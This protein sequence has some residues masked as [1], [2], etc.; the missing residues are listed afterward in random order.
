MSSGVKRIKLKL[1]FASLLLTAGLTLGMIYINRPKGS[2]QRER[3]SPVKYITDK[4]YLTSQLKPEDIRLLKGFLIKT[5]VDI[6]PD[7]EGKDQASSEEIALASKENGLGFHYIPVPHEGIPENAVLELRRV[8]SEEAAP[9]LLYCRTGR[10]AVRLFA[11]E[12]ASRPGGPSV[13]SI[14][15]L[16]RDAGFSAD[17]LKDDI[18]RYFAERNAPAIPS[19]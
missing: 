19:H 10:R 3:T 14:L 7:G 5:L 13:D 12:E 15:T 8:L 18:T 9:V 4:V 1:F 17:D 6:R 16:V 11:L 2:P